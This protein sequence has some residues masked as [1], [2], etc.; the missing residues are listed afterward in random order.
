M[1]LPAST[2]TRA[3]T[4]NIGN[5]D[6]A[7]RQEAPFR[8]GFEPHSGPGGQN[9]GDAK[10]NVVALAAELERAKHEWLRTRDSVGLQRSLLDLLRRLTLGA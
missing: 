4:I 1:V 3:P 2:S 7:Q 5:F 8:G 10:S 6:G 9:S